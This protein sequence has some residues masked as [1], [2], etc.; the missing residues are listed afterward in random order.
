MSLSNWDC[1]INSTASTGSSGNVYSSSWDRSLSND[2]M[3]P[4]CSGIGSQLQMRQDDR[5]CDSRP[6]SWHAEEN[7]HSYSTDL[8]YNKEGIWSS[9][10][11]SSDD[12][13]LIDNLFMKGENVSSV[14]S[15]SFRDINMQFD[16]LSLYSNTAAPK[17]S[18]DR[19]VQPPQPRK[20]APSRMPFYPLAS[21]K[22]FN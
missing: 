3:D 18:F 13:E 12:Y 22:F 21:K 5:T 15:S 2:I 4:G 9:Q 11:H 19:A 7:P 16:I 20:S 17:S 14:A 8:D 10:F 6:Q 1:S